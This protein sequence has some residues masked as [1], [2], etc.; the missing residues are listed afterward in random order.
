MTASNEKRTASASVASANR[1]ASRLRDESRA[2]KEAA[3]L[4][5][6]EGCLQQRDQ[7]LSDVLYIAKHE[8]ASVGQRKT[9]QSVLAWL[10]RN[11]S[12]CLHHL[13]RV[14]IK[15]IVKVLRLVDEGKVTAD[16]DARTA[17]VTSH[18]RLAP[19]RG[20]RK[21]NKKL[22]EWLENKALLPL[23]PPK[24]VLVEE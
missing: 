1:R 10:E 7:D 23:F 24:K 14:D 8:A 12:S 9:A 3:F 13:I 11:V 4:L 16:A 5:V 22:P 20:R 17:W 2:D 19:K 15:R 18:R 21:V 6:K